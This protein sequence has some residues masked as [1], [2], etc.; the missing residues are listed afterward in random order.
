MA[1]IQDV[2]LYRSLFD[3]NRDAVI[4]FNGTTIVNANKSAFKLFE[5]SPDEFIGQEIIEFTDDPEK[6]VKRAE[7]RLRGL[8]GSFTTRIETPG[9]VK[10]LEIAS[11]AVDFEGVTS[12][13]VIRDV[14]ERNRLERNYRIIFEYGRD[15]IFVTTQE[16]VEFINPRG[17][18]YLGYESADEVIGMH[19][20]ALIHP[21]YHEIATRYASRRRAGGSSPNQYRVKMV[22]R[23]GEPR[24]VEFNASFIEWDGSPAS[25]TIARDIMEQVRLEELLKRN[26][27]LLQ[28]F[29]ESATDSFSILDEDLRYVMVNEAEVRTSRLSR[30]DFIGRH[31]LEVFPKLAETERYEGYLGVLETGEPV[32]Y[33][34]ASSVSGTSNRMSFK[35]FKAGKYLGIVGRDMT[36]LLDAEEKLV[37]AN[38]VSE[39]FNLGLRKIL[40]DAS[41]T[42]TARTIFDQL[43]GLIGASSGYVALLS[44]DGSENEVLFLDSGDLPCTIDPLL[45]M[46]IRGLRR[47]AYISGNA[48]FENDFHNSEWW[49][50]LPPGHVVMN[51][52]LFSPLNIG[53]ETVGIIGLANKQGGFTGEDLEVAER[54]GELAAIALE[55]SR[56]LEELGESRQRLSGFMESATDGFVLLDKDL[57][58]ELVNDAWLQQAGLSREEVVGRYCADI[59][60]RIVEM[61]RLDAYV[62]VRDTGVPVEFEY[63]IHPGGDDVWFNLRA[64]KV[65]D[66][67]GIISRDITQQIQYNAKFESLHTHAYALQSAETESD[68]IAQTY[69]ILV[70]SMGYSTV[71]IIKVVDD[72]LVDLSTSTPDIF[73]LLLDGP[74]ITARAGRTGETQ[75][76]PDTSKDPDYIIGTY[77]SRNLS[78]LVVPVK[79]DGLVSLLINIEETEPDRLS[80]EDQRLVETLAGHVASAL[81][82]LGYQRVLSELHDFS[83]RLERLDSLESIAEE[84]LG[85]VSRVFGYPIVG[86]GVIDDT[87]I[88]FPYTIGIDLPPGF[89]LPVDSPSVSLRAIRSGETQVVE[90]NRLDPDH[91]PLPVD[92][93]VSFSSLVVPVLVD[94][95]AR[96]VLNIQ[97]RNRHRFSSNTVHLVELLAG[98]VGARLTSIEMASERVRADLAEQM[99][100]AKARFM[101]TATHELRTPLTS[102]KGFLELALSV[103]DLEKCREY[104]RVAARNTLRLEALTEDLLDQQRLE[105]DRLIIERELV[106]LSDM[107]S[108]VLEDL[109]E[110]F[111]RKDQ[112]VVL[113][114][115]DDSVV[116]FGDELR[117]GQVLVNLLDNASKYSMV[118]SVI[119]VEIKVIDD[120]AIVCVQDNGIGFSEEDAEKLFTPFPDIDRPVVSDQSVGLGLSICKGI[121]DLHGGEIWAESPGRG[122]GSKFTFSLPLVDSVESSVEGE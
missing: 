108:Y 19:P 74:G 16:H 60:P 25:L 65:G 96:M 38:Q 51:N 99:E 14:T 86:I 49:S 62:E 82:S 91:V 53:G 5:V 122:K 71:D 102:M 110:L 70:E 7:E 12:Y 13:S 63:C 33:H 98:H 101:R 40:S 76:V 69:E 78:E 103:D 30:E 75:L 85:V 20:L 104:L 41:F 100:E 15:L 54:F 42:E 26:M 92:G 89:V 29:I 32:E 113:E 73:E 109:S 37:R 118:D 80:V 22:T 59:F 106:D 115:P 43:K 52:V 45:P 31:I 90:D 2:S 79:V 68:V 116:V 121:I 39:A 23:C 1:D 3:N 112:E 93:F 64:F 72:R 4:F 58:V 8:S 97:T 35:A 119:R 77:E 88:S 34:D 36:S 56:N 47:E 44:K 105:D 55:H 66:G 28:E 17:V 81:S 107:I 9:G 11:T 117:L 67:V 61:G 18:E 84:A 21:D 46:P 95:N 57:E 10:E 27:D 24:D 6:S 94:N 48:V 120:T 87:C 114:M 83:I 50:F 111:L